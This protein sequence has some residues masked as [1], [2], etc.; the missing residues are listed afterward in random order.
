[1]TKKLHWTQTPEGRARMA[2][3]ATEANRAGL[4]RK[5]TEQMRT[6]SKEIVQSVKKVKARQKNGTVLIING[7]RVTLER[8]VVRLDSE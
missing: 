1:M 6:M 8:G 5:K 2:V 4:M 7:W 3:I